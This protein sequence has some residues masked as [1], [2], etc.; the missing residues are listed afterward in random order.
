LT[1]EEVRERFEILDQQNRQMPLLLL[2]SGIVHTIFPAQG[3]AFI[4]S[5]SLVTNQLLLFGPLAVL[6]LET[7]NSRFSGKKLLLR[8]CPNE[9]QPPNFDF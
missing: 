9:S 1:A 6:R 4:A 5:S 3:P 7:F 2:P 8:K